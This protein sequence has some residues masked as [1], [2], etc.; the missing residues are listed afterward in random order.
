MG[1]HSLL[2]GIFPTQGSNWVSCIGGIS[3]PSEPPGVSF[4]PLTYPPKHS[5]GQAE[6]KKNDI[7]GEDICGLETY[8][9]LVI[10]SERTVEL[11]RTSLVD[12]CVTLGISHNFSVLA[13]S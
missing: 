11:V 2:Q 10:S 1:S 12:F 6:Q 8:I 5:M 7:R 3:L 13:I 9:T 4:L